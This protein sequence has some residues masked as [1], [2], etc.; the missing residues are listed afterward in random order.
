MPIQIAVIYGQSLKYPYY[1]LLNY[2][3]VLCMK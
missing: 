1:R 2:A 3:I